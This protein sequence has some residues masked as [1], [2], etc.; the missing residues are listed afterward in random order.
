V[1]DEKPSTT[2]GKYKSKG[3]GKAK[4]D[5]E[6]I[7]AKNE[8]KPPTPAPPAEKFEDMDIDILD[9]PP[10]PGVPADPPPKKKLPPMKKK[11]KPGQGS[12]TASPAPSAK[13]KPPPP[14]TKAAPINGSVPPKKP[15]A[16]AVIQ[17]ASGTTDFDLRD[18]GIWQTL[19]GKGPTNTGPKVGIEKKCVFT[20]FLWREGLTFPFYSVST[21]ERRKQLDKMRDEARAKRN[22]EFV[23]S[24]SLKRGCFPNTSLQK[25]T[26]DL[27]AQAQTIERYE[28]RCFSEYTFHSSLSP[29]R[30]GSCIP[31][32][33]SS[34]LKDQ[35]LSARHS[36]LYRL[37]R[38][39]GR[40]I[41]PD[42]FGVVCGHQGL[43]K[44][45]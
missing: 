36:M 32:M 8:G 27:Q 9:V 20:G 37:L 24:D 3:K 2:R 19:I 18:S 1:E 5:P 6:K 7:I 33:F 17:N 15:G 30:N 38:E 12:S 39:I 14:T 44:E 11:T 22:E 26:F 25:H 21:E 45:L 29:F 40:R 35:V 4:G 42:K 13:S 34:R 43:V 31:V 28:V 41:N 16:A 10:T 23:G